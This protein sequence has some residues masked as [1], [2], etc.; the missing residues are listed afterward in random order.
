MVLSPQKKIWI[1]SYILAM[2]MTL[3][4][5]MIQ[6]RIGRGFFLANP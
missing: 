2:I 3:S 6:K 1:I 5:M 4:C